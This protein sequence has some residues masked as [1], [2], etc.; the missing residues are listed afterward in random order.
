MGRLDLTSDALVSDLGAMIRE[1]TPWINYRGVFSEPSTWRAYPV[2]VGLQIRPLLTKYFKYTPDGKRVPVSTLASLVP[3]L[4][5][6]L[7][8]PVVR[9][10][11][12]NYYLRSDG[13]FVDGYDDFSGYY[14]L[15]EQKIPKPMTLAQA[16]AT[17]DPVLAGFRFLGGTSRA[18]YVASL[19]GLL[20]H[21]VYVGHMPPL[22]LRG[23]EADNIALNL[24]P[25]LDIGRH[26]GYTRLPA[27]SAKMAQELLFRA[28]EDTWAIAASAYGTLN[29]SPLSAL[30]FGTGKATSGPLCRLRKLR[31]YWQPLLVVAGSFKP[32]ATSPVPYLQAFMGFSRFGVSKELPPSVTVSEL[33][34]AILSILVH[35][36]RAGSPASGKPPLEGFEAWSRFARDATIWAGYGDPLSVE[37]RQQE[38][39]S[40]LLRYLTCIVGDVITQ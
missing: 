36:I 37:S 24:F 38:G 1:R 22:F 25:L 13:V 15:R 30:Q 21:S 9:R 14:T 39:A 8:L 16:M 35:Y 32:K 23:P 5:D 31:P 29:L 7:D 40:V 11:V 18:A 3:K 6:R 17:L 4:V 26:V 28:K 10:V 27:K 34:L 2:E 12:D 20:G 19:F 33:R